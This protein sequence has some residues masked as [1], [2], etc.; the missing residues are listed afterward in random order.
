MAVESEH[1]A[2]AQ[3]RLLEEIWQ[4]FR[5]EADC[6]EYLARCRWP[7]GFICPKCGG[8]HAAL[9]KIRA[10]TYE[11]SVCKLQTSITAGT[12][13]EGTKL[14][15]VVWIQA[16][17][18]MATYPEE[19]S[20]NLLV[21]LFGINTKTAWLM[22]ER[23]RRVTALRDCEPLSASPIEETYRRVTIA[24]GCEPLGKHVEVGY[25]SI[26]FSRN[27]GIIIV[28]GA[29]CALEIRLAK[30][31]D[32]S[33]PSIEKFVHENVTSGSILLTKKLCSLPDYVLIPQSIE[34]SF[35][36]PIT[37]Q[38]LNQ[39][40]RRRGE[41]ADNWLKRFVAYHNMLFR[42]VSMDTILQRAMRQHPISYW[43]M[44]ERQNPRS[45]RP[46]IRISPRRRKT[47]AG[48]RQDRPRRPNR[49]DPIPAR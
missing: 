44:I 37:F 39:F 21:E 36:L 34:R 45:G 35:V 46:T 27:E 38:M 6:A 28:G 3:Q 29:I 32:D 19:I 31:A 40:Q 25:T 14:P 18:L 17:H 2:L 24:L 23:L 13:M 22:K 47:A 20:T 41:H 15:L 48:M 4:V 30:L 1:F 16:S 43:D 26:K 12:L 49:A 33:T 8:T 42:Q 11:C 9:L 7:S 5:D 10:Y